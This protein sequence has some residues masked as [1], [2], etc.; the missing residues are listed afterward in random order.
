MA[1]AGIFWSSASRGGRL[2]AGHGDVTARVNAVT[3][4]GCRYDGARDCA[5]LSWHGRI[6]GW[7]HCPGDG[8]PVTETALT[9]ADGGGQPQ[10]YV[11]IR[12]HGGAPS[13]DRVLEAVHVGN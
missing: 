11:P 7:S 13:T 5:G 1:G 9:S 2:S 3:H 8:G 12:R 4:P 10:V 6:R